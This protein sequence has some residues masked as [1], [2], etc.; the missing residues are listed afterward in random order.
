MTEKK[1]LGKAARARDFLLLRLSRYLSRDDR[2]LTILVVPDVKE[3]VKQ[4][5]EGGAEYA[6]RGR[7]ETIGG[8]IVRRYQLTDRG[9]VITVIEP[10][11]DQ[12]AGATAG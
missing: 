10:L 4:L 3:V 6:V 7:Q 11:L 5:R 9:S 1:R 12:T 2:K 8:Q